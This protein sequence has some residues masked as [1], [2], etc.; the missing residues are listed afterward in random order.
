LTDLTK[1]RYC[2]TAYEPYWERCPLCKAPSAVRPA[3]PLTF[4]KAEAKDL[5]SDPIEQACQT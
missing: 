5:T 3:E 1:C 2:G 4:A